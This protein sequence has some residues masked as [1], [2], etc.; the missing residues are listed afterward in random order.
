MSRVK[1]RFIFCVISS[2]L[3]L[4]LQQELLGPGLQHQGS[5]LG[6]SHQSRNPPQVIECHTSSEG[7]NVPYSAAGSVRRLR[8]LSCAG[9]VPAEPGGWRWLWRKTI[10]NEGAE[11]GGYTRLVYLSWP[12]LVLASTSIC[13]WC[14][15]ISV[16]TSMGAVSLPGSSVPFE[17]TKT[18]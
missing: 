7:F 11:Q 14:P 6:C 12:G 15:P 17:R 8:Q 4:G 16:N 1:C 18:N 2:L 13:C 10:I 3:E 9:V 5:A